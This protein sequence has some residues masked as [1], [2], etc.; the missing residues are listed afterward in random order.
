MSKGRSIYSNSTISSGAANLTML[1]KDGRRG[2]RAMLL[3]ATNFCRREKLFLH[4][5]RFASDIVLFQ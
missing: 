4:V 1:P 2:D 3:K 5:L